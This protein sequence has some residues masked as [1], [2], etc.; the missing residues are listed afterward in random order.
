MK[1]I[2]DDEDL[3]RLEYYV[4]KENYIAHDWIENMKGIN[5]VDEVARG[6]VFD[7]VCDCGNSYM[8]GDFQVSDFLNNFDGD[9]I[10]LFRRK[11]KI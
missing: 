6:R 9:D 11:V 7:C 3:A 5:Q 10:E 8:V 1:Y 4:G 2:I